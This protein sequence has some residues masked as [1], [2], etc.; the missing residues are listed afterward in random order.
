MGIKNVLADILGWNPSKQEI[1]D[2][3]AQARRLR[4]ETVLG[5]RA[6]MIDAAEAQR[7][8]AAW[9]KEIDQLEVALA[10]HQ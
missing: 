10:R 8:I 7:E 4:S 9:D 1:E 6:G 3:L 2:Q 5:A